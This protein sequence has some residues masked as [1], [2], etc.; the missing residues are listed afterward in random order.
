MDARST[1]LLLRQKGAGAGTLS[2]KDFP[3]RVRKLSADDP[4]LASLA[5]SLLDVAEVMSRQVERLTKRVLDGVPRADV[6]PPNHGARRRSLT[7]LAFRA[8]S[9]LQVVR[10]LRE[11]TLNCTDLRIGQPHHEGHQHA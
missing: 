5:E 1:R 10:N 6:S 7:A 11:H 9:V 2:S 4:V 3:T 8:T